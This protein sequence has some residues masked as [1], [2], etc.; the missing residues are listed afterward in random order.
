MLAVPQ[1][2]MDDRVMFWPRGKI[3]GGCSSHNGMVYVRGTLRLRASSDLDSAGHALDYDGWA[4]NGAKGWAYADC[5]PYFRKSQTHE[6]GEDDYR[7]K[8]SL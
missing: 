4:A 1:K 8:W 7:G 5:L 2:H 3:L 6:L